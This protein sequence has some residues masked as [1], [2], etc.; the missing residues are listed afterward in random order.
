MYS[1]SNAHATLPKGKKPFKSF[2][3]LFC[4]ER[5]SERQR[6]VAYLLVLVIRKEQS[7]G[8]R[9]RVAEGGAGYRAAMCS[10]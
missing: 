1:T 2:Q 5:E 10:V 8:P 6:P 9:S 7:P 3:T 4:C